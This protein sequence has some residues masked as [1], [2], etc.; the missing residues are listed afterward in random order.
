MG[1]VERCVSIVAGISV[2]A[3]VSVLVARSEVPQLTGTATVDLAATQS[4]AA[5]EQAT[6]RP[7]PAPPAPPKA[8]LPPT[9]PKVG[10]VTITERADFLVAP[11]PGAESKGTVPGGLLAA[12]IE[13][14]PGFY[15]VM[16]PNDHTGWVTATKVKLHYRSPA[17][18]ARS[19]RDATIVIDP[20]HGGHLPGAKGKLHGTLEKDINLEISKILVQRLG[21]ARVFL[22]TI[23]QHSALR[24]RAVL[25]N[26]LQ[27]D[28]F[29]SVHNNA[30]PDEISRQPGTEVYYSQK[31][32]S[33]RLAGLLYE[34]LFDALKRFKIQW[35]RDPFPGAKYR[36]SQEH[37]GDY[38]AVLRQ[39]TQPAVIVESM[40]ITNPPEE[41]LLR[42]RHVQAIIADALARGIKR[43]IMTDDPG[44]GFQD[45]Y[46]EPTPQCP[47][48]GCF[49]HRK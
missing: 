21:D 11:D 16:T 47:I 27:A 8:P 6:A 22:T 39:S 17:R 4:P 31:P 3:G 38:Y 18:A 20:G 15:H 24:Y 49:E 9:D 10:A 44:S 43:F 30:L 32:G 34:E 2:V 33:K 35:G 40:F 26:S 41:E 25:S 28:A 46:A 48:P 14:A 1:W 23:G 13:H 45:P 19:L 5:T 7:A 37:G 29:V 12:V 36:L 42:T